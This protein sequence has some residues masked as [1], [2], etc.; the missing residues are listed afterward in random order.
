MQEN[1]ELQMN[2]Y[3][4]LCSE[5]NKSFKVNGRGKKVKCNVCS[6]KLLDMNISLEDWNNLNKNDK[7][8]LKKRL[9]MPEIGESQE[10][11]PDSSEERKEISEEKEV[12]SKEKTVISEKKAVHS[13]FDDFQ[14]NKNDSSEILCSNCGEK[15]KRDAKFCMKCGAPVSNN[16]N[17]DRMYNP[18]PRGNSYETDKFNI[19]GNQKVNTN[20]TSKNTTSAKRNI[21]SAMN[22]KI[23]AICGAVLFLLIVIICI[24]V[25]STSTIDLNKYLIIEAK[26]YDGYGSVTAN[27]DW[28]AIEEKY[29]SKIS[30]K[31]AVKDKYGVYSLMVRP[32]GV[33]QESIGVQFEENGDLSNGDEIDYSWDVNENISKYINCKIKYKN[34]KYKVNDLD[35]LSTFDAFLGLEAEFS[36]T[37]PYGEARFRYN[38]DGFRTQDYIVG[39][40]RGLSNGDKIKVSINQDSLEY[41]ARNFG[42]IPNELEKEY[43]VRGLA[44]YVTKLSEI[45]RELYEKMQSD[46]TQLFNTYNLSLS[47]RDDL[48]SLECIGEYL[49]TARSPDENPQNYL[50]LVYKADLHNHYKKDE[51]YYDKVNSVYWYVRYNGLVLENDG[52]VS[53][54]LLTHSMPTEECFINSGINR[55]YW[56]YNGF[57]SIDELYKKDVTTLGQ[58][59]IES[60]VEEEKNS[61]KGQTDIDSANTSNDEIDSHDVSQESSEILLDSTSNLE[62]VRGGTVT[63]LEN[64]NIRDGASETANK[65]GV[66]YRGDKLELIERLNDWCKIQYGDMEAYVKAE[67]VE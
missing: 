24:L 14:P 66:A 13:F 12:T 17:M 44:S 26:G 18:N 67:F 28:K 61:A 7:E 8:E 46:A 56:V 47:E 1:K 30:F 11:T 4:Y 10:I 58:Y 39:E 51:K 41:Y 35:P 54:Q 2:Y 60:N 33:M 62:Q 57:E 5:C 42:E 50:F 52:K 25:R 27:I 36:G 38:G 43:E 65:V 23:L 63:V 59:N 29:G 20:Y 6:N 48:K 15:I 3:M 21:F 32:V 40:T 22:K 16:G 53:L 49:L 34:G 55:V 64:V 37:A 19:S 45:D 9:C 31:K